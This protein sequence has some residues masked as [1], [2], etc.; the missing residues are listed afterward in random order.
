MGLESFKFP[1]AVGVYAT[2]LCGYLTFVNHPW[3]VVAEYAVF[4]LCD[5]VLAVKIYPTGISSLTL[6][7]LLQQKLEGMIHSIALLIT[8]NQVDTKIDME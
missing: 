6:V 2:S 1:R 8:K 5:F 7:S 4:V 3:Y